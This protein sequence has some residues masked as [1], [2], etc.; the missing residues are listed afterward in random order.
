MAVIATFL[1]FPFSAFSDPPGGGNDPFVMSNTDPAQLLSVSIDDD[2][3]DTIDGDTNFNETPNDSNQIATVTDASGTLISMDACYVEWTATYTAANG[4]VIE[5]WRIELDN[6]L[7]IFAMSQIPTAGIVYSTSNKDQGAN[8]LDP[9]TLP[10]IPCFTAGTR[11][12][13][14]FGPQEISTLKPGDLIRSANGD[15]LELKWIGHRSLSRQ[16]LRD[17]PQLRPVRITAG[18]MGGGLPVRDLLV[19]R[20]HRMLV[21]SPIAKRMFGTNDVLIAAIRL[22]ELPGIFI[23]TDV[24]AIEYIHL[25]FDQHSVILAEG[26]PSE[27]L[28]TGVQAMQSV[29]EETRSEIY[30]LFPELSHGKIPAS[31]RPIPRNRQQKQLVKRHLRNDKALLASYACKNSA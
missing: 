28:F 17:H 16:D 31:A 29:P 18:A 8:G 2:D 22:T 4:D 19:S 21:S 23:D 7:R 1:G 27:S 12:E 9:S 30:H 3:G 26:T 25:L 24:Q 15:A 14:L 5:V 6:G 11:I 13:A 10:Q 20:Q